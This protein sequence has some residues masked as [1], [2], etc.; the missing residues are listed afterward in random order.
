MSAP[1]RSAAT[2]PR[3]EIV[4]VRAPKLHAAFDGISPVI[5]RA[6]KRT[7][8]AFVASFH[9][10][11]SLFRK[12]TGGFGPVLDQAS[13]DTAKKRL[14]RFVSNDAHHSQIR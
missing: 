2:G 13:S 7:V 11:F 10:D 9:T 8:R 14:E 6:V 5:P 1:V 12:C 3:E 4:Y